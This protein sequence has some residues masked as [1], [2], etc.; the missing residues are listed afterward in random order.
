MMTNREC[1]YEVED[2]K[3]E[4]VLHKMNDTLLNKYWEKLHAFIEDYLP[5][6]ENLKAALEEKNYEDFFRYLCTLRDMLQE[7]HADDMA[8]NLESLIAANSSHDKIR[9]RKLAAY[10]TYFLTTVSILSIDI[11]EAEYKALEKTRDT[12]EPEETKAETAEEQKE[13]QEGKQKILLAVDDQAVHLNALKA[14]LADTPYKLI[15]LSSGEDA[16]RYLDKNK[17][18][19]FIL[20]IL[21]P[22]MDGF[23]LAQRIKESGQTGK[24]IFLT[25][26]ATRETIT[27]A[28]MAGAA[29]FIVK[30]AIKEVVNKKIDKCL[31]IVQDVTN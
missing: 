15:C 22:G 20:D 6:E 9:H 21:M 2:L 24:I 10:I 29:D 1:L 30:P 23:E 7:I 8:S 28:L 31:G 27:K 13:E 17:P 4:K 26:T 16:L 25:G 18:D 12:P 19:L 11:Q 14:I 5:L 3:L